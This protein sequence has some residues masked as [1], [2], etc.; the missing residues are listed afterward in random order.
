MVSAFELQDQLVSSIEKLNESVV[1]IDSMRL[2]RNPRYGVVPL[3]GQGS[4]VIIDSNGFIVTNN[5]VID[6]ASR[7]QIHLRDGRSFEGEVVG[8]DPA[9]DVAL[10]RVRNDTP[11]PAATLAD[12]DALKVGQFAL[13]IG[14]T[15]GLPGGS[16]ASLGVIGAL[17]RPL[18]WAEF[19]FEGLIQT[20]AAINPGNS[21]GP[22]AD[23][24]GHVVGIN[25]AMIPFA[26]GVGFAIPINAVKRVVQQIFEKGRV[27]RP[28][29]GISGMSLNPQL[30]R[31]YNLQQDSGVLVAGLSREGPSFEAGFRVGD[32]IVQIGD[33]EVKQMKDLLLAL[34]KF[35][36]GSVIK[37]QYF[38]MGSKREA[39]LRLA[40]VPVEV[41]N[42]QRRE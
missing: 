4:G 30:A 19:I 17:G 34:S 12:S 2:T 37:V 15:L 28:W 16:T 21:G 7:V 25:T 33:T 8:S 32:V 6:G 27:I 9:T 23:I 36:V 31:R 26:Q 1:A 11:L 18:P 14:N 22:L 20:D 38:R 24:N 3:E 40:E 29:L 13:A 5:H 10:I 42:Y 35:E 41:Q 39:S